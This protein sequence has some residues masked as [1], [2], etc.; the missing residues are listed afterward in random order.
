MI[1]SSRH[2]KWNKDEDAL[3]IL[4]VTALHLPSVGGTEV[5]TRRLSIELA[6]LGHQVSIFTTDAMYI[7]DLFPKI[8]YST[9]H[10]GEEIF[11]DTNVGV[12]R[13]HVTNSL[14]VSFVIRCLGL[15]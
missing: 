14:I 7:Y 9:K 10:L 1:D 3:D 5:H 2:N 12:Y 6:R 8:G 4:H 13:F 11:N 15:T